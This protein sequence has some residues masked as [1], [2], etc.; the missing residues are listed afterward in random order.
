MNG[1][2]VVELK[3]PSLADRMLRRKPKVNA[4]LEIQNYLA[5]TPISQTSSDII[6]RQLKEYKVTLQEAKE[7]FAFFYAKVLS[8]FLRDRE[9]SEDEASDLQHLRAV[10]DL[11]DKDIR[12]AEGSLILPLYERAVKEA[13]A[14]HYITDKEREYL[15]GLQQRLGISEK[16]ALTIRQSHSQEI[17]QNAIDRIVADR[18]VSPEE[19]MELKRLADGLRGSIKFDEASLAQLERFRLLWR[20]SQGDI[21]EIEVD[22]HLQRGEKCFAAAGANHYNVSTVTTAVRYHGPSASIKIMKG[23]RWRVGQTSVH[24]VTEDRLK[25]LDSGVLYITN[26]RVLFDGLKK[27]TSINLNKILNYKLYQ[28]ALVIEKDSGKDQIFEFASDAEILGAVLEYVL[29][30]TRS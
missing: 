24:R 3:Q 20:I 14:D 2:E 16:A 10:L 1:L 13:L 7:A 8:H 11:S 21:P 18:R 17:F 22:I 29:A 6:Q 23:V 19:E 27:T 30:E 5:S 26:K 15:D 28:D 9:I 4:L 25:L 12:I